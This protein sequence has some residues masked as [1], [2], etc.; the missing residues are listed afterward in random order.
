MVRS[1]I[2]ST[3]AVSVINL[4]SRKRVFWSL[5]CSLGGVE[6][7]L[8]VGYGALDSVGFCFWYHFLG[9]HVVPGYYL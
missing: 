4:P 1:Y 7:F 2:R 5:G 3:E 9:W 6:L 8:D